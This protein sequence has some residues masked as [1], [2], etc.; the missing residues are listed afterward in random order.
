MQYGLLFDV[1][2][3]RP[4]PEGPYYANTCFLLST[5]LQDFCQ[6]VFSLSAPLASVSSEVN[7]AAMVALLFDSNFSI[8]QY[9]DDNVMPTSSFAQSGVIWNASEIYYMEHGPRFGVGPTK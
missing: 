7:R 6:D 9:I 5:S 8:V 2:S 4:A 3:R 1:S